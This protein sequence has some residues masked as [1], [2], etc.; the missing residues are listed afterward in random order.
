MS[1]NNL[2]PLEFQGLN[3]KP[4]LCYVMPEYQAK[5][6]THFAYLRDFIQ[7]LAKSYNIQLLIEK[8]ELPKADLGVYRTLLINK[9]GLNQIISLAVALI[10]I[11]QAGCKVVYIHYS[12]R[13]AFL[14]SFIFRLTGGRVY[15]WNCGLPWQ[16]K[17]NL[18]RLI[19]EFITYHLINKLITGT[20]GL[21]RRY[22]HHYRLN[23]S[24]IEVMPNWINLQ[25][26]PA[27]GP[28]TI[29]KD[30]G[31]T[32]KTRL[33]LFVHR[34]SERK[35]ANYLR[36]IAQE[37]KTESDVALVVIGDGPTMIELKK[38]I[39]DQNLEANI[40]LLGWL[41][42][43]IIHRYYQAAAVMIIPSEEEGFPH[44]LL[45]SFF[46][47]VPVVAFDV[48]GIAEII[49]PEL[50]PYLVEPGNIKKFIQAIKTLLH[51]SPIEIKN[52]E[53]A[54]KKWVEQ[55]SLKKV[56]ARF[57]SLIQ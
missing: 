40:K 41:P 2:R 3:L 29:K 53:T 37:L 24:K 44:V 12:F 8:G 17:K 30:L 33:V 6:H 26:Q 22:A 47:G 14:A 49:P 57:K 9:L 7:E 10:K 34:L 25:D 21:K 50:T 31:L 27:S 19:F 35:G 51:T 28:S 56:V 1:T 20:E 43:E 23:L 5:S 13:A 4:K 42:Q 54:E 38:E 39:K 48:G 32:S 52:L 11:R 36:A 45:E 55:F 46:A 18:P 15:Y 16:Y